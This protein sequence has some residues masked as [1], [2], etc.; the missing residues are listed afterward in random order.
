MGHSTLVSMPVC[1]YI[2]PPPSPFLSVFFFRTCKGGKGFG[3][4]LQVPFFSLSLSSL[5]LDHYYAD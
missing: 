5:S 2:Y 4:S 3:L 1:H